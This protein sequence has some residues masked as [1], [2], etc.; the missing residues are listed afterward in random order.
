MEIGGYT[1][2]IGTWSTQV[3]MVGSERKACKH[4]GIKLHS[5]SI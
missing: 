5:V 3:G 1:I 4:D 2:E